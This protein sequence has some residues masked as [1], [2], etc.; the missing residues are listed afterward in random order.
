MRSSRPG[1]PPITPSPRRPRRSRM[2]RRASLLHACLVV[3]LGT[4]EV[5]CAPVVWREAATASVS[6]RA[7]VEEPPRL[8]PPRD[9]LDVSVDTIDR[10]DHALVRVSRVVACTSETPTS[11]TSRPPEGGA[12][13][14]RFG[15]VTVVVVYAQPSSNPSSAEH[16]HNLVISRPR[17]PRVTAPSPA[18]VRPSAPARSRR[19]LAYR[20][21]ARPRTHARRRRRTPRDTPCS[22]RR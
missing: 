4:T 15:N 8:D 6:K 13:C 9:V 12:G 22:L 19:G 18:V 5:A 2:Q 20:S 11:T 3:L 1:L 16:A 7:I 21:R 10:G 14:S 17:A